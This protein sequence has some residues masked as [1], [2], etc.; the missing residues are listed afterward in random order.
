MGQ[1]WPCLSGCCT[2]PIRQPPKQA[3]RA[4]FVVGAIACTALFIVAMPDAFA[5][6]VH[7]L[8]RQTNLTGRTDLWHAILGV[9]INPWIGTGFMSF[10]LGSRLQFLWGMF[11]FYPQEAHNGYLEIYINLGWIGLA[12]FGLL[13]A[14]GY[15]NIVASFRRD[16]AM[17]TFQ[18]A[19][20]VVALTY[21]LTEAAFRLTDPIWILLLL[22]IAVTPSR[23]VRDSYKQVELV[24]PEELEEDQQDGREYA[25]EEIA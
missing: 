25:Y 10:W 16:P 24:D 22:T 8:G 7:A 11:S 13:L 19:Y 3:G 17:G 4:H 14:T 9:N 1:F 2:C 15:R 6:I 5:S 21:N 23:P 18:L 20:F 12:F